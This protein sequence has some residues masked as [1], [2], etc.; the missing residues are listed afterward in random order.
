V[1]FKLF[2]KHHFFIFCVRET[3]LISCPTFPPHRSVF[4]PCFFTNVPA[5][6]AP[7]PQFSVSFPWPQAASTSKRNICGLLSHL[8]FPSAFDHYSTP[9]PSS[10][11]Q[12]ILRCPVPRPPF[13]A[14]TTVFLTHHLASCY[15]LCLCLVIC[16]FFS[17]LSLSSGLDVTT[18][19]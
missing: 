10:I 4:Y 15:C 14:P 1:R 11:H 2:V 13:L 9:F 6:G 19:K 17:S 8:E 5:Y 18:I 16:V 7:P 12:R 3:S